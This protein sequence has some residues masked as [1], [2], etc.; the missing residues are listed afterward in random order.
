MSRWYQITPRGREVPSSPPC[1][2]PLA[3]G[4][5]AYDTAGRHPGQSPAGAGASTTRRRHR[6][7]AS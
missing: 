2:A 4:P 7:T 3:T 6:P 5:G 1:P